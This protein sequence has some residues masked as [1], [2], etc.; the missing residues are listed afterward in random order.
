M[1]IRDKPTIRDQR[2]FNRALRNARRGPMLTALEKA[3]GSSPLHDSEQT[4]SP[5]SPG[6]IAF[7]RSQASKLRGI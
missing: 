1:D 3:S 7:L 2:E 4:K 5:D 6:K